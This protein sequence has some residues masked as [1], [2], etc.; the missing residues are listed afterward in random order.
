MSDNILLKDLYSTKYFDK[1]SF[2]L[3]RVEM[4]PRFKKTK[5]IEKIYSYDWKTLELKA[6][7]RRIS[8]VLSTF[9]Y[10]DFTKTCSQLLDLVSE[11]K[12]NSHAENDFLSMFIPDY[13]ELYGIEYYDLSVK[14]FEEVTK[15]TSCEF[16]VRPFLVKY[17]EKMEKQMLAWSKHEHENV[18]RFSTEGIRPRLPWAMALPAYKKDPTAI[19]SILDNLKNDKSLFVRKSVANNL[20]DIS[21]DN[22]EIVINILRNWQRDNNKFTNWIIKHGARTLLKKG[23]KDVLKI[24]GYEYSKNMVEFSNFEILNK[25]K[26]VSIGDYLQFGFK[27]LLKKDILLRLEYAIHFLKANGIL[28]KKV[29]KISEKQ[30]RYTDEIAV[31]KKHNFKLISTR[32]Y[33]EGK[34]GLSIIVNG[35]EFQISDFYLVY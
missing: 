15:F 30:Y 10:S 7:M 35:N 20:N 2:A 29:F 6:R 8:E 34:H 9:F 32:K 26:K 19:L 13:I 23:D 5:F 1:L 24:F 21:K 14:L 28:S 31:T 27:I 11:L 17:P 12:K 16:A 22:P 33:Y 18:R 4:V 25:D 3:N